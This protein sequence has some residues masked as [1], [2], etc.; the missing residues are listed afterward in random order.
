MIHACVGDACSG[1]REVSV[2]ARTVKPRT[3]DSYD[4]PFSRKMRGR[5][6]PIEI[7]PWRYNVYNLVVS[8]V[9]LRGRS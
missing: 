8:E 7:L 2:D 4:C 9:R 3:S 5:K 1:N 6:M